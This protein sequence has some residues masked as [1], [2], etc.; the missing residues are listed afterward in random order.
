M[1]CQVERQGARFFYDG[2]E[3]IAEYSASGAMLRRYVHGASVDDPLIWYEGANVSTAS[4]RHLHADHQ[5]SI[6]AVSDG[7]GAA[8]AMNRY[9][10]VADGGLSSPG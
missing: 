4:R 5:G 10:G 3:L 1:K 2:D 8:L 7:N 9:D 6:I